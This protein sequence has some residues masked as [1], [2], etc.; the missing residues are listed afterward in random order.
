MKTAKWQHPLAITIFSWYFIGLQAVSV[1]SNTHTSGIAT[2]SGK[3]LFRETLV[4]PTT[5]YHCCGLHEVP[6]VLSVIQPNALLEKDAA[7]LGQTD[8]KKNWY[9]ILRVSTTDYKL[10]N[11][12]HTIS[13]QRKVT[14][15]AKKE[16][17]S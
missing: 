12:F 17:I 4:N 15:Y 14:D 6:L 7:Y 16:T 8:G 13:L 3:A 2:P 11:N 9:W 1:G 10:K 5:A